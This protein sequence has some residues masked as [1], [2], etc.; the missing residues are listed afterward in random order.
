VDQLLRE[1]LKTIYKLKKTED[2]KIGKEIN[3]NIQDLHELKKTLTV[4]NKESVQKQMTL[5][6]DKLSELLANKRFKHDFPKFASFK[7]FVLKNKFS[8]EDLI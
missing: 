8:I 3:S 6:Q 2:S 5:K 7:A 1:K 4:E